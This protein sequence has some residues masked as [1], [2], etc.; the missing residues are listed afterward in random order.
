MAGETIDQLVE[1]LDHLRPLSLDLT[2]GAPE[3][4]P[5]FRRLVIAARERDIE[6][7][8]RSNLTVLF[9][10]GQEGLAQFL[11]EQGGF[12]GRRRYRAE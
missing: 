12:S 7:I 4:N 11:A 3:L 6:V 2:G 9:E 8:D 1:L 10:P 5:H